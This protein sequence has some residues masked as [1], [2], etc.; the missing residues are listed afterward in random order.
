MAKKIRILHI[1]NNLEI[2]GA[3]R[4][5]VLLANELSKNDDVKVY[6]VS[7]EGHGPLSKSLSGKVVLKEF[8]YHL[9]LPVLG[10]IDPCFRLGLLNY[11][12]KIKPDIIH[13]HLFMGEDFAKVLGALLHKPV[14]ITM[15]DTMAVPGRKVRLMNRYVTKAIAVSKPVANHLAEVYGIG[16]TRISLIPNAIDAKDFEVGVKKYNPEKP[17]FLYIGRLLESKGVDDAI[18]GLSKLLDKYP[19]MEFLIYGKEV[20]ASYKK[21][22][23]EL[24]QKNN[25]DFVKFMGRTDNVPAALATGDVF[26]SPS[27]TEGFGISVLEAAAAGK[28]VIATRVG[29]IPEIVK[30]GKSGILVDW[31]K[32]EQIYDAAKKI[33]VGNQVEAY[34]KNAQQI[35]QNKY[36]IK[37]VSDMHR[38]LYLSVLGGESINRQ[39]SSHYIV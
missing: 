33:I 6:I 37:T 14:V 26:I 23:D 30:N 15:H 38:C 31:H 21:Y 36:D 19:K 32:P 27:Q 24:V 22:L 12:Q 34:G 39:V 7:L 5:L 9:F 18:V 1:I 17:V 28:P 20:H 29:A 35:A 16:K 8:K 13:G 3:E 2:G 11:A 10:R 25:W 4:M